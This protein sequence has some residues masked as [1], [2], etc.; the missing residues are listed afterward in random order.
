MSREDD[1]ILV[2]ARE[3]FSTALEVERENREYALDDLVMLAAEP[4]EQWPEP[5]RRERDAAGRI[6]LQINRLP[7]FVAQVAGDMRLNRPA[8][9]VSP[10]DDGSDPKLAEVLAGIIR[11]IERN[12]E[13]THVYSHAG[14]QAAE[15]G[16]GHFRITTEYADDDA[17]D[18][19][20][21]VR[22]ILNPFSVLWDPGATEYDRSDAKWCFVYE[23]IPLEEFKARYP[24][25]ATIG[26]QHGDTT[27]AS[28]LWHTE[29]TIRIAEYWVKQSVRQTLVRLPNGEVVREDVWKQLAP[30]L[31]GVEVQKRVV[32]TNKVVS[33]LI[34]GAEILEGP[35]E[36]PGRHIPIISVWGREVSIGHKVVRKSVIRDAKDSQRLYN[37]WRTAGAES[38]ALAPKAPWLATPKQVKGFEQMWAKSNVE[39]RSVLLFNPDAEAG[40]PPQRQSPP[41][42]P[43]AMFQEAQFAEADMHGTT[44]IYPPALGQRSNESSGRAIL[45]RQRETDVGTSDFIDNLARSV[46]ACG[47]QLVDLIPRIYD[48]SRM[49]RI[50]GEDDSVQFVALNTPNPMAAFDPSAPQYVTMIRDERGRQTILPDLAAGKYDVSVSTGPNFSTKR[51]ESRESIMAFMQAVPQAAAAIGDLVAKNQDWPGADE[52]AK[53]LRRIAARNG[54]A[55][56]DPEDPGS[57]PQQPPP[58][59][60]MEI[61]AMKAQADMAKATADNAHRAAQT[62][63]VLLDNAKK[64]LELGQLLGTIQGMVAQQVQATLVQ[65]LGI[66]PGIPTGAP[67]QQPGPM[68]PAPQGGLFAAQPATVAPMT[69]GYPEM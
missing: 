12:S 38:I 14:K 19:D 30:N 39:N 23:D 54:L 6:Y 47:R 10:V 65:L 37:F 34:S 59:P 46:A 31:M 13:A 35:T 69:G 33:Y 44:G 29:D 62:E 68:Q 66:P 56:P 27:D 57:M 7:Q 43:A 1:A 8:I 36:W 2:Q 20:I 11:N 18:L 64:E 55:D 60:E 25:A 48:A 5:V 52:I 3:R 32:E 21:R 9:K 61:K 22:R 45:A 63:S 15:C 40:G 49:M 51:E 16:M 41:A 53:R 50:I 58:D 26:W 42:I 67:A 17:F 24:K 4:G 28:T